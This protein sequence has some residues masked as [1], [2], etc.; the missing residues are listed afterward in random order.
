MGET[1]HACESEYDVE[2]RRCDNCAHSTPRNRG[3]RLYEVWCSVQHR[4]VP[5]MGACEA[6]KPAPAL[7]KEPTGD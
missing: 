7:P 2:L 6:W 4:H 5:K 1:C 3:S